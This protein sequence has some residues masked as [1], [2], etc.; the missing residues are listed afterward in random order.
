MINKITNKYKCLFSSLN[1]NSDNEDNQC[2]QCP[3]FITNDSFLIIK[4]KSMVKYNYNYNEKETTI[5]SI[6]LESD[7][8]EKNYIY[9]S[10]TINIYDNDNNPYICI[11]SKDN[12]IRI[13]NNNLSIIKSYTLENKLKEKYLSPI[14]I[15]CDKIGLNIFIGKNFLSKIDLIKQKESF[16]KYNKN[17]KLLS[18]FDF[19]IKYSC[20]FLGSYNNNILLCDYKTDKIIEIYKQEKP[21]NDI[22]ILNNKIY[23]ILVGYRNSD[24]F[25]LFDIRKMNNYVGKFERNACTT[26]KINFILDKDENNIYT[27]DINGNIIKYNFK[28]DNNFLKEEINIGVNKS[29]TG[30]DLDN[31]YNLLLVS[32]DDNID[33]MNDDLG[34]D[35]GEKGNEN[36]IIKNIRKSNFNIYKI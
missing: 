15:K 11:C 16:I 30:I 7:F 4:D 27:G 29:I 1:L 22:K 36:K 31:K 2:I 6:K 34:S 28:E 3:K 21:V 17:Y 32:Y 5:D 10:D 33:N 18:C 19:N 9:D 23:E 8:I 12:P 25:C 13:L 20:Y 14:F 35:D 26:K 24:F